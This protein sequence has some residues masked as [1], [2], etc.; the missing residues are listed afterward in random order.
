MPVP[1][2][3][4]DPKNTIF[5]DPQTPIVLPPTIFPSTPNG[6]VLITEQPKYGEIKE[7]KDG[8]F[9]Y[10]SKLTDPQSTVVDVVQFKFT[11]QAGATVVVRKEFVLAQSGDVPAIIQ[12]GGGA[13]QSHTATVIFVGIL[14]IISIGFV[15]M[16]SRIRRRVTSVAIAVLVVAG[17]VVFP[18]KPAFSAS[19]C[20]PVKPTGKSVG[21]INVDN[22]SIP[23]KAFNYPEGG[24]MSPQASTLMAALSLR[25]MPLSSSLGSSLVV[26]HRDYNGCVNQLNIFMQKNVGTTFKITDEKGAVTTYRLDKKITV[27]K[28][29]YKKEWFSLIGPRQIVMV[30][31][32]GDFKS[33]HYQ[34]N[35]VFIATPK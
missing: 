13:P 32:T 15:R 11:N 20:T 29:N 26:W 33:G 14:L 21:L 22:I 6:P 27:P 5:V 17:A 34:D 23:I 4:E 3:V 28:G 25:H 12:T 9:V 30:T 7:N 19:K 10:I 2:V 1:P 35:M 24:V 8:S 18:A 31:C 16:N